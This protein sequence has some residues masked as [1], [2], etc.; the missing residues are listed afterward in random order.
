[1]LGAKEKKQM[2]NKNRRHPKT[3]EIL[4]PAEVLLSA[5]RTARLPDS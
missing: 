2:E 1:M 5:Q 3:G 4:A